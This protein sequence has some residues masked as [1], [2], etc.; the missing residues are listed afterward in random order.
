M[1]HTTYER[2][3]RVPTAVRRR[4][5]VKGAA[6]SVPV[7][8]AVAAAP[9]ASASPEPALSLQGW[10]EIGKNCFSNPATLTINGTGGNNSSPPNDGRRG[11]WIFAPAPSTDWTITNARITFYYPT[12][13]GTITWSAAAGN[14]GWSV[15]VVT[16]GLDPAIAGYTAYTTYY[17]GTWTFNNLTGTENDYFFANGRPNFVANP[18]IAN[19]TTTDIPAYA[20]RTV[21][22]NGNVITFRR[23]PVTLT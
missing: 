7:V 14:S 1:D 2:A 6:W 12:T 9:S 10:V 3:E 18:T 22:V 11:L 15:P 23:G 20:Q 17:S 13:L 21:T 19:C 16:V 4:N 5:L 8:A